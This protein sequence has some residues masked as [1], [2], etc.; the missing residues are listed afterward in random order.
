MNEQRNIK[1]PSQFLHLTEILRAFLE[2]IICIFFRLFYKYKKTGD[3]HPVLVIPGFMGSGLSTKILRDFI[4][5]NGYNAYDWGLDRNLANF[6]H[7]EFLSIKIEDLFRR[8]RQ[9]VTLI[10][11]S[12]GGVYAR[13]LA[14]EQP[15]MIRQV[16]TMGA[17]F[18]GIT[19]PNNARWLYEWVKKREGT[20]E[21]DDEVLADLP[22]PAP[23]PTT[24]IHSKMDGIVPWQVCMEREED[25]THQNIRIVGSHLGFGWNPSALKIIVDRLQYDVDNW[26]HYG[27]E[28]AIV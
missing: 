12:L 1:K 7:L 15:D 25:A 2:Y 4:N 9:K 28:D 24:A 13:Q 22:N 23:V 27:K 26:R 6:D 3:G 19:E 8:H 5:K 21:V 14:K 10:G 17:P 20:D 16:I 11:W 18:N